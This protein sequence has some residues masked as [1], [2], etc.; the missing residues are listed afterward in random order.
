M[1]W[2]LL[3]LITALMLVLT[4]SMTPMKVAAQGL[5]EYMVLM[6]AAGIGNNET[7]EIYW[8]PKSRS[9]APLPLPPTAKSI[10]IVTIQPGASQPDGTVCQQETVRVPV[11]DTAGLKI[12]NVSRSGLVITIGD[13]VDIIETTLDRCYDQARIV[14]QVGGLAPSAIAQQLASD[15]SAVPAESQ[16]ISLNEVWGYSFVHSLTGQTRAASIG[17]DLP[18]KF[19]VFEGEP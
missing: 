11:K 6:V 12:L 8:S 13:G 9:G 19:L 7:L 10:I 15:P 18:Q 14:V 1:R 17:I 3:T 2:K 16:G 5:V 4:T